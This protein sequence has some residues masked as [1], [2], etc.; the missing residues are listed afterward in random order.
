M[1]RAIAVL[2][3]LAA[4]APYPQEPAPKLSTDWVPFSA[5]LRITRPDG[6]E[7]AGRFYRDQ[8][9][10]ERQ[11]TQM[12]PQGTLI[13]TIKNFETERFYRLMLD[14]WSSQQMRVGPER[15][16]PRKSGP[17]RASPT[18]REGFD[19]FPVRVTTERRGGTK[20]VTR[21]L[22]APQLDGFALEREIPPDRLQTAHSIRLGPPD[23]TLFLP[24][25]GQPITEEPGYGGF[26]SFSA[27]ELRIAFPGRPPIDVVT[28]E[29]TPY[30]FQTPSGQPLSL[31][32]AVTDRLLDRVVIRIMRNASGRAGNIK[33]ELLEVLETPLG[34]TRSTIRQAENFEV[35][36]IRIRDNRA[37]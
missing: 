31:V 27:V 26:M 21:S 19:V 23:P 35:T 6:S 9:G 3:T 28:T 24:P 12:G 18:K 8:H 20:T 25:A 14:R 33:G 10:C 7:S 36:V 2:L 34:G 32:V 15:T 22:V 29:E 5:L 4:G 16:A 1:L 17:T 11:E 30:T 37:R 13:V